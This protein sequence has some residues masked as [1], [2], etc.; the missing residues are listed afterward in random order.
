MEDLLREAATLVVEHEPHDAREIPQLVVLREEMSAL[1]PEIDDAATLPPSG[2]SPPALLQW[3]TTLAAFD[4]LVSGDLAVDMSDGR[5]VYGR[6]GA[7]VEIL[8][9]KLA[10]LQHPMQ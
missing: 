8:Q 3:R 10:R 2:G 5:A 4:R 7:L 6:T 9:H 1:A